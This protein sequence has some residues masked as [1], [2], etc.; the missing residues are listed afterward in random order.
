LKRSKRGS[1]QLVKWLVVPRGQSAADRPNDDVV[2][3]VRLG[4]MQELVRKM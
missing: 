3:A 4:I 2:T 1:G